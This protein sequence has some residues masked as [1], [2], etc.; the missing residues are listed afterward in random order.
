MKRIT[1]VGGGASGTLLTINLLREAGDAHL[2]INLVE[3]RSR[4]G[5]GVAFGTEQ[6][7]HLLNVPAG[8][9]GAFPDDIGHFHTW[10][11]ENNHP[12]TDH[13]FVPRKLFG[14]YLRDLFEGETANISSNIRLNLVDDEAVDLSVN[15][16]SAEVMLRS[17]EILP[18]NKVVL[19]FGNFNPPNP[20]VRDLAFTQ[21]N[22]YFQ[23]PWSREM[24]EAIRK[25]DSVFIIGTGL[26][27]VDVALHLHNNGHEG[28]ITAI[29]T[30]GL[31]PAVHELGHTYPSFADE[32]RPMTR[33]TDMVK[34]VRSHIK[35]AEQD[36]SNWR[37]V[38][39]SL[40]AATPELWQSL[41]LA[42][43][44][45]FM[46]HLSRYWNVARH[47]MPR[48]AADVLDAM[49][50]AGELEI[51]KGR[52]HTIGHTHGRFNIGFKNEQG[53]HSVTAD[54]LVNCIGS[55]TNFAKIDSTF[56]QNLIKRNHIRNDDLS[57]GIAAAPDGRVL[58][59]E[60]QFS[61]VVYTLG[62]ALKGTL[63]ETTAIPEIR[64]QAKSLAQKLLE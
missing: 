32:L 60:G 42:E 24:Y 37:G 5:R 17:G 36:G 21:S 16:T 2:E 47:R 43:K 61:N 6:P 23:D 57:Q 64:V 13:D 19:A 3:K 8:R 46:Q 52:L 7:S 12:Y 54:I 50:T 26:S 15:G 20:Y 30:R 14:R 45:Y 4:V 40:R 55:Q 11:R 59:R 27:M 22:K 63:W 56:V 18:S 33:I 34:C 10:L 28:K 29:S 41:P 38:I 9:M 31:L 49:E 35:R 53:D 62:T 48:E 25:E 39:D 51:L 1:I 44:R 58:D